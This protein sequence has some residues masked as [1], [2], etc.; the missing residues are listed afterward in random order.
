MRPKYYG[1]LT[2]HSKAAERSVGVVNSPYKNAEVSHSS[3][4]F[5]HSEIL[6]VILTTLDPAS[7]H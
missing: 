6:N 5:Y 3:K 1:L 4:I 2:F 7:F